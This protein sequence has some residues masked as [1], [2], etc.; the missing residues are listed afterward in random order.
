MKFFD[1]ISLEIKIALRYIFNRTDEKFISL[2]SIFSFIGITLGVATLIIVMSVMNG[3]RD[4]L[5]NNILGIAGHISIT[6]INGNINNYTNIIEYLNKQQFPTNSI[7][8]PKPL[9]IGQALLNY[10]NINQGIAIIGLENLKD[11]KKIANNLQQAQDFSLNEYETILSEDSIII[12]A[13]LAENLNLQIG[14]IVNI[15]SSHSNSSILGDIPNSKI[16]KI[17]AIFETGMYDIDL[18]T[19]YISIHQAQ[20]LFNLEKNQIN[21]IEIITKYPEKS[22]TTKISLY[23][24]LIKQFP[25]EQLIVSDWTEINS[26]YLN[27]LQTE[28]RVMFI[29]LSLIILVAIFNIASSLIML[30]NEKQKSIAVLKSMGM[31]NWAILRIFTYCG[32]IISLSGI[33]VGLLIGVSF[34]KNINT[35]KEFLENNLGFDFFNPIIYLFKEIPAI[36]NTKDIISIIGLTFISSILIIIPTALKASKKDPA[37]ILKYF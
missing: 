20:L 26:H 11:K 25:D 35:I 10:N 23:N 33:L 36:T 4:K 34:I 37:Q 21:R 27:A 6:N 15:I 2:I 14:D 1:Y 7:E 3:F 32:I 5:I 13:R 18:S 24:L 19:V 12:G 30:I 31:T 29:I 17:S 16:Y 8:T 9:I 28:K 22:I